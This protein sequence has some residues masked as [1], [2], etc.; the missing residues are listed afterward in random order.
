[1]RPGAAGGGCIKKQCFKCRGSMKRLL[2]GSLLS[3]LVVGRVQASDIGEK[4]IEGA[5]WTAVG[6]GAVIGGGYLGGRIGEKLSR[7]FGFTRPTFAGGFY[8]DMAASSL[9]GWGCAYGLKQV[10]CDESIAPT[11]GL[12]AGL[13]CVPTVGLYGLFMMDRVPHDPLDD[14]TPEQQ[15]QHRQ[16]LLAALTQ[17]QVRSLINADSNAYEAMML[18]MQLSEEQR[19]WIEPE[20]A[21]ELQQYMRDRSTAW[22]R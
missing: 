10:L 19:G 4:L 14:M 15:Q 6:T 5:V 18:F 2:L 22:M 8:A 16:Q 12:V 20:V 9:L 17:D 21:T 7:D 3:C 11:V 1:M 13:A